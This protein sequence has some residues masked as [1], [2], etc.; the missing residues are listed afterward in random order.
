VHIEKTYKRPFKDRLA[1]AVIAATLP[2]PSRF[3]LALRAA[4]VARP[5][6]DLLKRIPF[7]KT[8]GVMLD[9]APR[10]LPTA[11]GAAKPAVYAAKGGVPRGRVAL[12]TGC[13]QPVL[14]PEINEA[15]IRLLT[16]QG[17]EVVVSAGEGCCGALVHHMG[18][19]EEALKAARRN[20]D[21]WLKAAE[22][23]GL[24]AI[25]ITAS[26]CGTTIK[27]YGHMLRLDPAYAENAAKVSALAKDITEYLAELGLPE[28]RA[29]GM[30]VAYHSA[31]S[32]QH[33]QK[34]TNIPKQLLKR[35]GF[36]V[37]DPAEGH[38]C[39]GSAGTYNIL[40]PEISAK[41]K[42]RKVKNIEATKPNVIATG[43]IGCITQIASGTTIPIL[44]TV[45]LLDWAYGG[46]RPTGL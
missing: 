45:E 2:Y 43:N 25:V 9:L 14:K 20:V 36:T 11:S 37:R 44:H 28:Q 34:I 24:D 16:G 10:A 1:R 7:L 27:D 22:E 35:A 12:L 17:I 23:D 33:G 42:A 40:Q 26:G 8:F 32:M 18:R 41:L 29:R 30:T 15:T 4:D 38:L 5:F 19:E 31:C 6:A 39:C 21:V 3:R 13:A 46:P